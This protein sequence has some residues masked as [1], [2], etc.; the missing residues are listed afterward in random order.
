MSLL[1]IATWTVPPE[2]AALAAADAATDGAA[3]DG[4]A[5]DGAAALGAVD[6]PLLLHAAA[7][8][9]MTDASAANPR[10][11]AWVE[12]RTMLLLLLLTAPPVST[13]GAIT[14]PMLRRCR[15][16][17]PS[18]DRATRRRRVVRQRR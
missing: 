18:P 8:N 15:T 13:G 11:R 17:A 1:T 12:W 2:A 9:A 4:A 5:A 3:T 14:P 6:A 7:T 16:G 10:G